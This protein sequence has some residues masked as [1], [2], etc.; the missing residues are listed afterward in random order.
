MN[1]ASPHSSSTPGNL[2]A[3]RPSQPLNGSHR[4]N[5]SRAPSANRSVFSRLPFF[6]LFAGSF[7]SLFSFFFLNMFYFFT[8]LHTITRCFPHVREQC[9]NGRNPLNHG[10]VRRA[11]CT[12]EFSV[13]STCRGENFRYCIFRKRKKINSYVR[14]PTRYTPNC[15]SA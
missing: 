13:S 2:C 7:F 12:C 8:V 10:H 11:S 5:E 4:A 14:K 9:V 1:G 3:R 6:S 15:S